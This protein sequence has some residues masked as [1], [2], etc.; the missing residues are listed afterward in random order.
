MTPKGA[1]NGTPLF[2]L[3][4]KKHLYGMSIP[5]RQPNNAHRKLQGAR[6]FWDAH[7]CDHVHVW[8]CV[9]L[10]PEDRPTGEALHGRDRKSFK[11]TVKLED[12]HLGWNTINGLNTASS[13]CTCHAPSCGRSNLA[14]QL[15]NLVRLKYRTTKKGGEQ[16]SAA[17]FVEN[18]LFS[19][20]DAGYNES[21]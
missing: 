1:P 10:R 5:Q 21:N 7:A 19:T 20:K 9:R 17:E 3:N 18:P 14:A 16:T 13:L 11:R 4:W 12:F 6:V 8:R 15:R 2:S